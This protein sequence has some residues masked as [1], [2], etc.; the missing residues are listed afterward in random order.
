MLNG[1]SKVVGSKQ[2]LKGVSDGTIG[3]VI[4]ASDAD[5]DVKRAIASAAEAN[6]VTLKYF[7][8]KRKLG[9]AAGIEVEAATVGILS[10][11][12]DK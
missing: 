10:A 8:S 3:C 9:E 11:K 4:I 1:S 6:G 7:P 12:G 2:V 5:A